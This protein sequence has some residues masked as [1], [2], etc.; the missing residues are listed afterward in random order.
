MKVGPS[1]TPGSGAWPETMGRFRSC[2]DHWPSWP[3]DD[4]DARP[5]LPHAATTTARQTDRTH[6]RSKSA[7]FEGFF[8]D[9]RSASTQK[10]ETL[11][12]RV[13]RCPAAGRGSWPVG[14]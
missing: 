1:A 8:R 3:D 7:A 12:A 14:I 4:G 11:F 5:L 6:A 2:R 10:M 13:V 9:R